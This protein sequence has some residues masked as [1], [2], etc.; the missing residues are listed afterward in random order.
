MDNY[1]KGTREKAQ[2]I[3]RVYNHIKS[4]EMKSLENVGFVYNENTEELVRVE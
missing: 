3:E 2:P 4:N 1:G